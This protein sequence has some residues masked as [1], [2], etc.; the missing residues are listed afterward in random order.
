MSP[1]TVTTLNIIFTALNVALTAMLV[2]V[3]ITYVIAAF[4]TV[5]SQRRSVFLPAISEHLF[6]NYRDYRFPHGE[7]LIHNCEM[8]KTISQVRNIFKEEYL[9]KG[10]IDCWLAESEHKKK[11]TLP[12]KASFRTAM[13]MERMGILVITGIIPLETVLAIF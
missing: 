5:S 11:D 12:N 10:Q 7:E 6:T 3:T 2:L 13:L 8:L 4:W 9:N 1:E